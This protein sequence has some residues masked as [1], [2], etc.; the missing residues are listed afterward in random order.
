MDRIL[1]DTVDEMCG[2]NE[3]E[4]CIFFNVF[5]GVYDLVDELH[6]YAGYNPFGFGEGALEGA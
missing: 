1:I 2:R 6:R 3:Q 4:S 5:N